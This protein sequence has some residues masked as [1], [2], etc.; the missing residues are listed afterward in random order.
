MHKVHFT[1]IRP[2]NKDLSLNHVYNI[3][4]ADAMVQSLKSWAAVNPNR[5]TI[6]PPIE[7]Q[8]ISDTQEGQDA[9]ATVAGNLIP[10]PL[11]PPGP[12]S[13]YLWKTDPEF[14]AGT[15]QLR[16]TILR[17]TILSIHAR[18]EAELRGHR[19]S[20][21][22]I[23]EQLSAQQTAA[24]SPPTDTPELDLALC[25]LFGYQKLIVDEANRKV[26]FFPTDPRTWSAELPVWGSSL[27]SRAVLHRKNEES[28]GVAIAAWVSGR[29]EDGW[30]IQWPE[31]EGTL[32]EIKKKMSDQGIGVG[33]RIDKPKKADYSLAFGRAESISHLTKIGTAD[34]QRIS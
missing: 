17:D 2:F 23:L 29:E 20:R 10:V 22:K 11:D 34:T 9:P 19:W 5:K 18:V 25:F 7:I 3:R 21:K 15:S 4:M 30:K 1:K 31:A 13:L 33:P 16:R 14:R 8:V 6:V 27:G 32:E 28:V 12:V 24:I 26:K